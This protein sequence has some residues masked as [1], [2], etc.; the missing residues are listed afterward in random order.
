MVK[1]WLLNLV[2]QE[3]YDSIIYYNDAAKTWLDL[4]KRFKVSNLPKV[5]QLEQEILTLHQ[6]YMELSSY[7]T[8]MKQL[9]LRHGV[10]RHHLSADRHSSK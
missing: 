2:N 8:K 7:Y 3:I 4:F 1:S 5:Y 9:S 10:N 6:G